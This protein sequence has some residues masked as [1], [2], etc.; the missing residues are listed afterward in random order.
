M[1]ALFSAKANFLK[2]YAATGA[3]E[4]LAFI[5]FLSVQQSSIRY[6]ILFATVLMLSN[7]IF[8]VF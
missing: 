8:D 6:V 5:G 3:I 2:I 7:I 4:C 1:R